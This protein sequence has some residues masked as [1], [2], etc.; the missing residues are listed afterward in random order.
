MKK[1]FTYVAIIFLAVAVFFA[2]EKKETVGLAKVQTASVDGIHN[3]SARVGGKITDNG[4]A[5]ITERGIYWGTASSP[6]SSGTK[7]NIGTGSGTFYDT[8]R[9][10]SSGKKYYVK[11]F[12]TNS[13]GTV[14]GDETFFTTQISM[15][16]VTTSA[17]ADLT[18]TT[19]KLGGVVVDSGGFAV[20]QRGLYW[21]IVANPRVNGSKLILGSGIG[22]FSQTFTNLERAV[23]Y[24]AIAFATNIKG[25]AYGDEISFTTQPELPT[26]FTSSI[27]KVGAYSAT[28]GGSVSANGGADVTE[29]GVCWGTSPNAETTG[30]KLV[31][32]SGTGSFSSDLSS[33]TPGVTYYAKAFA[34]NSVGTTFGEEKTCITL[35]SAPIV[36]TL[37]YSD[38]TTNSV[39]LH[40]VINANDLSTAVSFEYGTTSAYGSS[41][42]ATESPV[43]GSTDTVSAALTGLTPNTKYYYRVKAVNDIGTTYGGD[44][45]FTTVLTGITGSVSDNDGNTYQ[46]IGVGYQVWIT[47]NLKTTK[48]NDGTAI[49]L[50]DKDTSWAKLT[51]PGYCWYGN[52][53]A[54]NKSTYG[55]IYN[56]YTVNTNKL[57]PSGW[58][59]PSDD[60]FSA[61]VKYLGGASKAG[62]LLKE[63]GLSHWNSPNAGATNQYGFN[64]VGGGMR[65]DDGRFDF[66]KV[67]GGWW[68]STNY[69]DLNGSYLY[70]LF[71]YSNSF[72][73]YTNKKFGKSVRCVKN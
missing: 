62:G 18:P 7:L 38:L 16:T 53:E 9:G 50:V 44:S 30:T 12:A 39:K 41:V 64:A 15:P 68:G 5:E 47:E 17:V 49:P 24:Y 70:L 58:H 45:T 37:D 2:C 27:S 29:R 8:L 36:A 21:G 26:V 6:V 43:T 42:N 65:L 46:T 72:Q 10:L 34:T 23:T 48:Y 3:T 25:T 66:V 31:V 67:E 13:Q 71:N 14:Y 28:V 35:G 54:I 22:E 4:G 19:A 60:E 55:A 40:G 63:A 11:A 73:G 69:S 1:E 51:S 20:T 56:W 33:L 61:L 59:V 32:G 57:C 52:N